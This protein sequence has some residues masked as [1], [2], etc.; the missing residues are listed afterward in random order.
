MVTTGRNRKR[1]FLVCLLGMVYSTVSIT[2][3]A[4]I[5]TLS[6]SDEVRAATQSSL[7]RAQFNSSQV[8]ARG[9]STVQ[10]KGGVTLNFKQ[11]LN[12]SN[13]RRTQFKPLYRPA[14][15]NR[16]LTATP[17]YKENIVQ[18][19]DR[20]VVD[21]KLNVKLKPGVCQLK[22]VPLA[23]SNL[24][25]K[26]KQGRLSAAMKADLVRVRQR[27][28]KLSPKQTIM[29]GVTASQALAMNDLALLE[30]MLNGGEREVRRVSVVPLQVHSVVLE[31]GLRSLPKQNLH[32]FNRQLRLN[33]FTPAGSSG[34]LRAGGAAGVT[35]TLNKGQRAELNCRKMKYRGRH[36]Q[37]PSSRQVENMARNVRKSQGQPCIEKV[38]REMQEALET[39]ERE[40]ARRRTKRILEKITKI[41]ERQPR[42]FDKKYFLTGFSDGRE[43]SDKYEITFAPRVRVLGVT[44]TDRYYARFSYYIGYGFG[45]RIPLTVSVKASPMKKIGNG[46]G[47]RFEVSGGVDNGG[48]T[49]YRKVGLAPR[50]DFGGKEF[51][52]MFTARCSFKASIPGPDPPTIRCPSIDYD[53]GKNFQPSLGKR[54]ANL[55]NIWLNG[56]VTGLQLSAAIASASLDLGIAVDIKN[57]Q[58]GYRVLPYGRA[59]VKLN[60]SKV[61]RKVTDPLKFNVLRTRG[62]GRWGIKIDRPRYKFNLALTPQIRINLNIDVG[63]YEYDHDVGPYRFDSLTISR[64]LRLKAHPG[65]VKKHVFAM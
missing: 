43:I 31:K 10:L 33:T 30:L 3:L 38:V 51:V 37:E 52:F 57:G 61:W 46:R 49:L 47:R 26:K 12:A 56:D 27:L 39:A 65:T 16:F 35:E 42:H 29:R 36:N 59:R 48:Q 60:N 4:Q 2:V 6:L 22:S 53:A 41:A 19:Q 8:Q 15:Q 17:Q 50:Y 9:L 25:F 40:R 7:F 11:Y 34:G 24:C 55:G 32:L 62:S 63:I 64:Q 14:V 45:L 13:L 28:R 1:I 58:F 44:I 20:L 18:L 5:Q 21:R 23:I 54:R